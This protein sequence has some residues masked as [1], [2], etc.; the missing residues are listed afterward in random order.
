M[1]VKST[2]APFPNTP[3]PV[4]VAVPAAVKPVIFIVVLLPLTNADTKTG[5]TA[6]PRK[7][8]TVAFA[9]GFPVAADVNGKP[10]ML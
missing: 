1:Q 2:L 10:R 8:P 6:N 5:D 4:L 7:F 9:V 3:K